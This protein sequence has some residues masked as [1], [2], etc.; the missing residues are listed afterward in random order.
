M[1]VLDTSVQRGVLVFWGE[2]LFFSLGSAELRWRCFFFGGFCKKRRPTE[3]VDMYVLWL[4][5]HVALPIFQ[6]LPWH[7]SSQLRRPQH[8]PARPAS[9]TAQWKLHKDPHGVGKLKRSFRRDLPNARL[10]HD[11]GWGLEM[12]TG[13][14]WSTPSLDRKHL[15][16]I[17]IGAPF[18]RKKSPHRT[19]NN[20]I[21]KVLAGKSAQQKQGLHYQNACRKPQFA[22]KY[23]PPF[24]RHQHPQGYLA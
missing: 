11:P 18:P 1:G 6:I 12:G 21:F 13:A 17:F 3:S 2:F 24:T 20:L 19:K 9:T 5:K 7:C 22:Q 15:R 4:A 10:D 23:A 8:Q 14:N 16:L